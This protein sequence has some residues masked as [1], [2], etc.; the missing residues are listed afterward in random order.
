MSED[1]TLANWNGV[2]MPL[3]EVRVSVLD[4]AFLFGDAVYEVIRLH[5][6]V[7]FLFGDHMQRLER[8]L[9][10]MQLTV[11]VARLT[12]RLHQTL[13]HSGVKDGN[14]YIQVTRGEAPR[15]H[16]FPV[17]APVPNEL[18]YV[19]RLT[20]DRFADARRDGAKV[21]TVPDLRW[22]RCDIKSVNLLANCLA[23]QQAAEAGCDEA[24]L[25]SED[26]TLTEG[27]QTSLF[28]VQ[29]GAILTAPLESNVLPGITR[30][31]VVKLAGI[32]AIPMVERGIP[33]SA[34]SDLD[35]LFLTG[36]TADI[37]PVTLVDGRPIGNGQVGPVTRRLVETFHEY[38]QSTLSELSN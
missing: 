32:A 5:A 4:R 31:L 22:K 34:L 2:E 16:R 14:I 24:I 7:P 9:A 17:P 27:T 15:T 3:E 38:L 6:G 20:S 8:N 28:G 21:I 18:I 11:D 37:L 23:A 10:K 30:G 33:L 13:S 19:K 29:D 12:S 26:G 36:T 25:V 1:K 35:E